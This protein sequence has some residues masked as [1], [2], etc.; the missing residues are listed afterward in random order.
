MSAGIGAMWPAQPPQVRAGAVIGAPTSSGPPTGGAWTEV[1]RPAPCVCSTPTS[2]AGGPACASGPQE[3]QVPSRQSA[4][5]GVSRSRS[6]PFA[7]GRDDRRVRQCGAPRVVTEALNMV[8]IV[9]AFSRFGKHDRVANPRS[10]AG[11]SP[12]SPR[13]RA[14]VGSPARSSPPIRTP[15]APAP[16][17]R[18]RRRPLRCP[19]GPTGSGRRTP[20]AAGGPPPAC[21]W[22]WRTASPGCRRRA[23]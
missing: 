5:T 13:W 19:A 4:K 10:G 11:R 21:R 8:G 7:V 22:S 1:C 6:H 9:P 12:R 23:R 14:A 17:G 18:W 16:P 3:R 20:T 2:A 15:A